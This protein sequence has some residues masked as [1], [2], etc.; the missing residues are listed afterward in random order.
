ML[1]S[2]II[3]PTREPFEPSAMFYTLGNMA[4]AK[5]PGAALMLANQPSA[6]GTRCPTF[7]LKRASLG[8]EA[9]GQRPTASSLV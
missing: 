1:A 6:A 4:T 2:N 3:C 9:Q 7:E 5:L 8:G